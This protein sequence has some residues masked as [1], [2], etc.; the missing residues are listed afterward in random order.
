MTPKRLFLCGTYA[1]KVFAQIWALK[2]C[3]RQAMNLQKNSETESLIIVTNCI[4]AVERLYTDLIAKIK[5][6]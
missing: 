4:N 5:R 3:M 6:N 2:D 1:K